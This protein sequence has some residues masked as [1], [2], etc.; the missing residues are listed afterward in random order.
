MSISTRLHFVQ[1]L[2]MRLKHI[3]PSHPLIKRT[4]PLA[5]LPR[6]DRPPLLLRL[7]FLPERTPLSLDGFLGHNGAL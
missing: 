2:S 3:A 6:I 7:P 4:I 1:R 5:L